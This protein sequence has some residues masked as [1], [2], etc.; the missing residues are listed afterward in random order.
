MTAATSS[1]NNWAALAVRWLCSTNH[2]D[3]GILY[4]VFAAW[5]GVIATTMSMLIRRELSAPGPGV[6]NGNGQLYNVLV[7][8]HGLLM[9][10]FVVMPALMGGFGNFYCVVQPLHNLSMEVHCFADHSTVV[11]SER[12]TQAWD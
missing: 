6:L 1:N 12:S 5:C 10:F 8:A 4:L 7:T 11:N 2:K 9:L 3:I